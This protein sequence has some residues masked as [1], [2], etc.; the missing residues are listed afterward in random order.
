MC[1]KITR[2]FLHPKQLNDFKS[3]VLYRIEGI[4][5]SFTLDV[6]ALNNTCNVLC[7]VHAIFVP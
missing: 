2:K 5:S 4:H 1:S 3:P 6:N 7:S